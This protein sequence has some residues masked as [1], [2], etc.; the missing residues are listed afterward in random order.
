MAKSRLTFSNDHDAC[1]V[2]F[3]AQLRGAPSHAVIER[4]L[5]ALRRLAHRGGVDADGRSGDGAGLLVAIPKPFFR[6]AARAEGI[7]LPE[8]FGVG[9]V[10]LQP[11]NETRALDALR[12]IVSKYDL[13]FL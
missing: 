10:F 8:E 3:I 13:S 2:G 7:N 12:T 1:G 6:K 9:M 5:S 11:G 4:G